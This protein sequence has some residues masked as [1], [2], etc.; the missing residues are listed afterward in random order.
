MALC[1]QLPREGTSKAHMEPIISSRE[2]KT[3][4]NGRNQEA[5]WTVIK[6]EAEQH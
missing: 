4:R 2:G 5:R 1:G 6:K 3:S